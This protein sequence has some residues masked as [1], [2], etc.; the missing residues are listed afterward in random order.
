MTVAED[1]RQVASVWHTDF[2]HSSF[3]AF[4]MAPGKGAIGG[5][6]RDNTKFFAMMDKGGDCGAPQ[7]ECVIPAYRGHTPRASVHPLYEVEVP[8]SGGS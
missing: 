5:T 6:C 7:K 2:M 3:S 8:V 1:V 4:S